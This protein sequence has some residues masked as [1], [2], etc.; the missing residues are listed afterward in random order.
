MER[1]LKWSDKSLWTAQSEKTAVDQLIKIADFLWGTIYSNSL[2]N[3]VRGGP[4][5]QTLVENMKNVIG[6]QVMKKSFI[7]STHDD[8]LAAVM[9]EL[10]VFNNKIVPFDAT[11]FIELHEKASNYFV[12]AYFFNSVD[13]KTA[14]I[15]VKMPKCGDVYDCPIEKFYEFTKAAIPLDWNKECGL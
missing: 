2:I 7:Y 11:V 14:P 3:R 12:R 6:K 15:S 13:T 9:G 5:V 8:P 4:L 1:N 10:G